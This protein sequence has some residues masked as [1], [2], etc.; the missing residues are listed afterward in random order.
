MFQDEHFYVAIENNIGKNP[1]TSTSEWSVFLEVPKARILA[2]KI[3]PVEPYDGL[4]W[5]KIL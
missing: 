2:S 4:I 5:W 3:P 1:K